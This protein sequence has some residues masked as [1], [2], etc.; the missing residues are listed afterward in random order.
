MASQRRQE[1]GREEIG[2]CFTLDVSQSSVVRLMSRTTMTPAPN[3]NS[4]FQSLEW[5]N[6]V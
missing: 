5:N 3:W 2:F 6:E 4:I 1:R